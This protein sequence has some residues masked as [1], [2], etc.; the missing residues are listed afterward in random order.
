MTTTNTTRRTAT[1]KLKAAG[2]ITRVELTG[3]GK[4]VWITVPD[5]ETRDAV[6]GVLP[7]LHWFSCGWGGFVFRNTTHRDSL[8]ANDELQGVADPMHY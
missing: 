8:N 1:A 5:E 3:A 2:L 4:G 7:E 6:A